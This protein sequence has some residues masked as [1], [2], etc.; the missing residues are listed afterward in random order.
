MNAV[1]FHGPGNIAVEQRPVPQINHPKDIVVRVQYTAICGSDLHILRGYE[2]CKPGVTMGHEFCGTI[3]A[4]GNEIRTLE[5]GDLIL[6]PF[7]T[8]CGQ[9]FYCSHKLSSRCIECLVFGTDQLAG[10]Q[11]QYVRVPF[12][13]TTAL[14]APDGL[15][16]TS[17]VLMADIFPTGVSRLTCALNR[18]AVSLTAISHSI[19]LPPALSP[20]SC[21]LRSLPK[22]P[23]S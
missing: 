6:S 19:L 16:S 21:P 8:S 20:T 4:I 2:P 14:K 22:L 11:A 9:C 18:E 7:T 15:R 12:A 5:V 23:L 13:D 10:A 17:L 3:V 1:V